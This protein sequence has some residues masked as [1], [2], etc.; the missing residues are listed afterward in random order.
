MTWQ[1]KARLAI[2][3]FAVAF[4]ALI[5]LTYKKRP[6][7][8]TEAPAPR[9]DITAIAESGAGHTFRVKGA[10]EE[11]RVDYERTLTYAD[12]S[13][14]MLGIKVTTERDGR[15][16]VITGK[17]GRIGEREA[18]IEITGDVRIEASDGMVVTTD[19]AEYIEAQGTAHA[20]GPVSFS[21][22]RMTGHG[23]GFTYNKNDDVLVI[24]D[25]G[26]LQVAADD[27]GAGAMD[28]AAGS[29]EFRRHEHLLRFDRSMTATRDL[30]VIEADAAVAHLSTD[31]T[32]LETMEMRG[33]S[34]MTAAKPA[35][36]GLQALTG[37]DIDLR[38]A[39][40][41]QSIEHAFING[42]AVLQ[43]AGAERRAGR[44]I[45]GSTLDL[46]MAADGTTLT[47][48]AAREN[49]TLTIP[50]GETGLSRVIEAE[51]L[52]SRGD[53]RRGLTTARFSGDVRFSER[54]KGIERSARSNTL[55]LGIAPGFSSIDDARFSGGVRFDDGSLTATAANARYVLDAGSL[56]LSGADAANPRPHAVNA[57]MIVDATSMDITLEG[58]ILKASG[59]VK[60]V[61]QPR[62][63]GD[64]AASANAARLPSMLKRDQPVNVTAETLDYPGATDRATYAGA[65]QLWQGDTQIK[66][67][68][69]VIDGSNGDL[70]ADGPVAT[71]IAL[72]PESSNGRE[73]PRR[74]TGTAATAF[75]YEEAGNR[76]TY[77]GDVHITGPQGDM[78][79][80]K[81]ELY[82][83]PSGDELER[84]EAY[85]NVVLRGEDRKT[86][87][88]RLTYFADEGRY[89]VTGAPVTI[90][91]A[92]GGETIGR[93]LTFYRSTDNIIVDGRDSTGNEQIRT[94]TTGKS[95]CPGS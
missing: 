68:T 12:N 77:T 4:A 91:D 25:Q 20:A 65:A 39:P 52:D 55:D 64:A 53:E 82:L 60:S 29:I 41:G 69:I 31:E 76:A 34:R 57:Q 17:E 28:V 6:V 72:R 54:G 63:P 51:R 46:S 44:Q 58:P 70:S 83:K 87:G 36:G 27:E 49:V 23:V 42:D 67:P 78:T 8:T 2:A 38:Y 66:A 33:H 21:R 75:R 32:T 90:V 79:S 37:R 62:K 73:E 56:E 92:C 94:Q 43:L 95:N 85:E 40:G 10:E 50:A 89:L 24:H 80:P 47:A 61:L 84:V 35:A 18:L 14:K 30:E 19:Q 1:K 16:F 93:T 45:A 74:S 71:V 81:I 48:L 13:T 86:T 5:A 22:G 15:T 11:V 7:A 59:T 9:T 26:T 88:A 3:L